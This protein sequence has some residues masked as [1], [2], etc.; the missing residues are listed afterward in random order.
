MEGDDRLAC[1]LGLAEHAA[2]RGDVD[3]LDVR[4]TIGRERGRAP[5]SAHFRYG[6]Q[7]VQVR[8]HAERMDEHVLRQARE[9]T[10]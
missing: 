8:Q 2:P 6:T 4:H 1:A 7:F 10:A 3:G 5:R 9:A